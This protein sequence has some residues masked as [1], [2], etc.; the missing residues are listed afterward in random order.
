[1]HNTSLT[2][3]LTLGGGCVCSQS[4]ELRGVF[5]RYMIYTHYSLIVESKNTRY[6]HNNERKNTS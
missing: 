4:S 2:A 3:S 6:P 5:L 1:M